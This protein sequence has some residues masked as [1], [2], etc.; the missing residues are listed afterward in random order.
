MEGRKLSMLIPECA[1]LRNGE[2]KV[3]PTR[4]YNPGV[5]VLGKP[6]LKGISD[7]L[8]GLAKRGS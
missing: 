4:L 1:V 3:Q 6:S 2:V 7:H 5:A 8:N